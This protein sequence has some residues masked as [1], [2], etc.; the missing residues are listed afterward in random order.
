MRG[1]GR[2][3]GEREGEGEGG[4]EREER[5]LPLIRR[6]ST[7]FYKNTIGFLRVAAGEAEGLSVI[8]DCKEYER[9]KG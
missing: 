5:D 6:V 8:I 4:R 7:E 2:E 1:A 9:E 3:R